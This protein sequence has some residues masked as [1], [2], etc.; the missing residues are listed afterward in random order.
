[1]D[2]PIVPSGLTDLLLRVQRDVGIPMMVTENGVACADEIGADGVVHDEDRI[3]YVRD[4][5]AATLDAIERGADVRGYYLWTFLDNFEWAWGYDKRFGL[6][7]IDE[8]DL[9]RHGEGLGALVRRGDRAQRA[10]TDRRRAHVLE[11]VLD[12]LR[13]STDVFAPVHPRAG[14]PAQPH[15]QGGD[16]RG[17]HAGRPG[18][19]RADRLPPRAGSRRGRAD[20]R[21]LPRGRSR[22]SHPPRADRRGRA[23]RWPG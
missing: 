19:R 12:C 16:L 14:P 6:V 10:R 4:H 8:A 21:R 3:A 23:T 17:A 20:H 2:W 9:S 7:S 5:L 1:M 13:W 11:H 15:G 22:G 18:D